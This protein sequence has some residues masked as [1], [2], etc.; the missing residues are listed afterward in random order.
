[1]NITTSG[2][3]TPKIRKLEEISDGS[4]FIYCKKLFIK[5]EKIEQPTKSGDSLYMVCICLSEDCESVTVKFLPDIKVFPAKININATTT[6]EEDV[7]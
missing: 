7:E 1:M 4:P 5:T 3:K 6:Y 2:V